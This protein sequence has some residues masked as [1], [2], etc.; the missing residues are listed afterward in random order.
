MDQNAKGLALRMGVACS[1]TPIN[2]DL[3]FG[4]AS[5]P[6][7]ERNNTDEE[8]SNLQKP[9]L[10]M[11]NARTEKALVMEKKFK[12]L[13]VPKTWLAEWL[14]YLVLHWMDGLAYVIPSGHL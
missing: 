14:N 6:I 5:N 2:N 11:C 7:W 1:P 13:N 9:L 4:R 12:N 10:E 8:D 3:C